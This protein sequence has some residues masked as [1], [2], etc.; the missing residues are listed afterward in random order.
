[1][2]IGDTMEKGNFLKILQCPDFEN[3]GSLLHHQ[4]IPK[5]HKSRHG[6]FF[7]IRITFSSHVDDDDDDDDDDEDDDYYDDDDADHSSRLRCCFTLD[8]QL[9]LDLK[10]HLYS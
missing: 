6:T 2:K 5:N 1:M 7:F 8:A 10:S 9:P 4:D 3:L